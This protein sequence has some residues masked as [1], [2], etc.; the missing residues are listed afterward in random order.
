MELIVETGDGFNGVTNGFVSQGGTVSEA[1]DFQGDR[2]SFRLDFAEGRSNAIVITPNGSVPDGFEFSPRLVSD[3]LIRGYPTL[4]E[5]GMAVLTELNPSRTAP[6]DWFLSLNS[7]FTGIGYT[8][9]HIAEALPNTDSHLRAEVGTPFL[10]ELDFRRDRDAIGITLEARAQY[11]FVVEGAGVAP[12]HDLRLDDIFGSGLSVLG[13]TDSDD[14]PNQFLAHL[15]RSEDS[16]V[17]LTVDSE[18]SLSTGGY[19]LIVE[20]VDQNLVGNFRDETISGGA[21]VDILNGLQ[22]NDL[23]FAG[24]GRDDL[25]G[26]RGMDTLYGGA[27]SDTLHGDDDTDLLGGGAGDDALYGDAGDD[28]VFGAAGDDTAYGGAGND[29]VGGAAGDDVLNGDE[30]DDQLWGSLGDDMLS[31]GAGNDTLG[32]FTGSDSLNGGDG[33]DEMWGAAGNDVLDGGG[34]ADRLGG[35]TDN[36]LLRGGDGD[37]EMFGGLGND[38]M[39]GDAGNDTIFGAAGADVIDGGSGDDLIYVGPGRD[40]VVAASGLDTVQFFSVA[41]DTVDLRNWTDISDFADLSAAHMGTQNGHAVLSDGN[42][43]TLALD[44]VAVAALSADN[45][46][47]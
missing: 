41:E 22:G 30:G 3:G 40:I 10:S 13:R 19:E 8:V 39:Y 24:D 4:F 28:R 34:D 15:N 11:L 1:I 14:R 32:G 33:A 37:D 35:G 5:D 27:G 9:Q 46:L 16:L 44:G 31:G 38:T 17:F 45:F 7:A 23:I 26:D 42:G 2:D 25:S 47:F 29:V 43:N 20:R 12:A 18:D 36:D 6:A 21:G